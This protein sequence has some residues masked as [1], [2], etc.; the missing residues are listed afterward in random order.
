MNYR[1]NIWKLYAVRF[2]HNLIPA[3]V[4]E[5]LFWEQRGMTIQMVVY[6]EIIYAI[7]IV[8][9][10][11]PTG[12]LADK[13]SRKGMLI[14]N[15]V[16]G[17]CEFIILI[18]ANNFWNFALAVFLAGVGRSASSGAENA[19][20]YDS[21][22]SINEQSHFEKYL[23][24]LNLFDIT[25]VVIAALSGSLFA[26]RFG[27][28]FNYWISVLGMFISLCVSFS[29]REPELN[30]GN[31]KTIKIKDYLLESFS[32]FQKEKG[33]WLILLS[34][35]VLG[36][37]LNFLDEFWQTYLNRL[38]IPVIYFGVF[39][40]LMMFLRLP[41]SVLAY[42]L[43]RLMKVKTII[44]MV[45]SMFS[46]GMLIL[47]FHSGTISLLVIFLIC[48]FSGIVDPIA[49]GY[50]HHRIESSMRATLDSFQSL[51]MRFLLIVIGLG[52]GFFSSRFDIFGGYGFISLV[53]LAYLVFF[54]I[55]SGNKID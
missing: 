12:I 6:T 9:L 25:A 2:F 50:L 47:S 39:S 5:R 4:I 19:L 27:Y 20:L 16:L 54:M 33:V 14:F 18:Y 13:F 26:N 29:L 43:M 42:K 1:D 24:R 21:L 36:S 44:L 8:L 51:I 28:E 10:E 3:Y 41:G 40:A 22:I 17:V 46:L 23:G 55:K 48:I 32:F 45:C 15:A 52:F 35:T 30:T 11:I 38:G 34:A 7:T 49:S 53:C 37:S 31:S